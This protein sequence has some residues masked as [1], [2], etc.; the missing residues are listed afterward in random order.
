MTLALRVLSAPDHTPGSVVP[1]APDAGPYPVGAVIE[2]GASRCVVVDV[3]CVVDARFS[4][5]QI[6]IFDP[7]AELAGQWTERHLNQGFLRSDGHVS[8]RTLP[9][10]GELL[11]RAFCSPYVPLV[12]DARVIAV[13]FRVTSGKVGIG[14]QVIDVAAGTYRLVTCQRF[15]DGDEDLDLFF[16]RVDLPRQ[17][18]EI[19]VA[20]RE[21]QPE[22]PLLE[23]C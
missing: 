22:L 6:M 19:L 7:E 20:D 3:I 12:E 16:E 15:F 2:Q 8:L 4:A 23:T 1:L 5:G 10:S 14:E 9:G 21:L 18:S 13:P 11:V 17:R